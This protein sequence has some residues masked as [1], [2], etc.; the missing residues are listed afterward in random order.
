MALPSFLQRKKAADPKASAAPFAS[1]DEIA[2]A[3]T[4]ARRRLIGAAVLLVAG[5][6]AFPLLFET[7]PRP[8]PVDL[9]IE[10]PRKDSV[11][12]LPLPA[13]VA[14]APVSVPALPPLPAAAPP[15]AGDVASAAV[16]EPVPAQ[17]APAA[18]SAAPRPA[19]KAADGPADKPAKEAPDKA[20]DKAAERAADKAAGKAADNETARAKALL[21]GQPAPKTGASD[22][23]AA[24][25]GSRYVVQVGAYAE[26]GAVR[27]T[28]AKV[29]KLG[30]KTY[31]QDVDT[32]SGK[33]TRVRIGPFAT[34][35]EANQALAR[36]KAAQLGGAVLTL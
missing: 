3:R 18:S 20:P 25:D 26:M 19:A 33:R 28:R 6:I 35:E 27:E 32:P 30:F 29:E 5:V 9:P 24:A 23:A 8:I 36:L 21:D 17:A 11:E 10:I 2:Q 1:D 16:A 14:R 4:R 7:Q 31:T 22:P 34:R 15:A 13:K 12:P